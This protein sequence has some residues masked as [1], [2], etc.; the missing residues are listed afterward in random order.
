MKT[1]LPWILVVGLAIGVVAEYSASH[2][3]ESELAQLREQ[4]AELQKQQT[5][6]DEA[7]KTSDGENAELAQLRQDHDDLLRLRAKVRKLEDENAQLAKQA[8]TASKAAPQQPS[9]QDLQK[10]QAENTQL[11]AQAMFTQ[12]TNQLNACIANMRQ[13]QNAKDQWAAANGRPP[14][15]VVNPPDISSSFP[16][17]MV[18]SCPAGGVYTLN[19]VGINPICSTPGHVLSK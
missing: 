1:I 16:N 9:S 7:K 11:R 18:P 12:A 14:G 13:I 5:P 4:I 3:M 10:L 8:Q 17:K 6:S 2:K 15:S 19:P